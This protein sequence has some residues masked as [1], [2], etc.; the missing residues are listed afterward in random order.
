MMCC[1]QDRSAMKA[2]TVTE[3]SFV[4]FGE[5]LPVNGN[6]I[7]VGKGRVLYGTSCKMMPPIFTDA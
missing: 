6:E 5:L 2:P 7:K 3:Q 1:E 4:L